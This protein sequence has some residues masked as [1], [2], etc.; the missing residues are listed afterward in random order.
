MKK[1]ILI[2]TISVV[3]LATILIINSYDSSIKVGEKNLVIKEK[4]IK[5]YDRPDLAVLQNNEMTLDPALGY[6]PVERSLQ[7]FE[8][9]RATNSS[10]RALSEDVE[11]IERGPDNVGG[12]TRALMFD[13]N[14]S[15][16]KKVWAGGIGGG[17]WYIND[18]TDASMSWVNV[19]DFLANLAISDIAYDPTNTS[20]FYLS[21]GLAYSGDIRGAGIFKSIDAG[22]TWSQISSTNNSE[23]YFVQ[24]LAIDATGKIY[25]T[26][27][28]G[29]KISS[30]GG[31]TWTT[32][33]EGRAADVE[34]ASNG[35]VYVTFG[36]SSA[37]SIHKSEDNGSTWNEITPGTTARRIEIATAPSN[38]NV[39]YAVADGGPA[40]TDVEWFYKSSDGGASWD[41][42]TIPLYTEQDCTEGTNHFTRGQAFFDLILGVHP[43][44]EN[45]VVV[46]GIDL[47]V[48]RDGG[49]IWS[50][51][52]YWTGSFC[53]AY[54]HAD[55]HA[56]LFRPGYP[57][58]A[59]FGND[60]G[61]SYSDDIGTAANPNFET[62]V[63]GYNVTTFY[64]VAA[65][66]EVNS[67]YFLAGAQDNG[68]QQFTNSFV[69]STNEVTGGDG[70]FCFVDQDDSSIQISSFVFNAYRLSQD[71][72]QSF[73]SIS[74]EQSKG[75]FINPTEYDSDSDVLY[76]AGD[77]DEMTKFTD[78]SGTPSALQSIALD[79]DGRQITH[80]K[81]SPY[82]DDRLFVGVRVSGGEGQIFMIDN[83]NDANPTVTEITGSY[84][85]SHG[86]WVSSI[87]VGASDDHLLATFSNY[88]INSI[89]ETLDGGT[90]WT[91][92]NGD[93][94]DFPVRWGVYNPL[95]R[96][97]V[98][99]A[100]ELGVWSTEDI[101]VASPSWSATNVGLA[102]VRTD[103]IKVRSVDN[104]VAVATFG[105]GVFTTNFISPNAKADFSSPR[106]GYV[107]VPVQFNDASIKP[108]DSWNW[109]F[110]DSNTSTVQNPTNTYT[111]A[112]TY[113]VSL[114]VDNDSDTNSKTDYITILPSIVPP[115]MASDGGDFETNQ[116]HF[117]SLSLLNGVNIWE[118]GTPSNTFDTAPSGSNVWKTDLDSNIGDKGFD[119]KSAIYTPSFDLSETGNYSLKFDLEMAIVYC[120][121]P[122]ALQVQYSTDQS[123]WTT[124][125]SSYPTFGAVNWYNRGDNIGCSIEHDL[126][127][128]KAGWAITT[129]E[130][131]TVEHP[132]NHLVGNSNVSFRIVYAQ[133]AGSAANANGDDPYESDGVLIDDFEISFS[134]TTADFSTDQDIVFTGSEINFSY[135]SV[136][137]LTYSWDFGDGNTSTE[138]NPSHTYE[139]AGVYSVT[140]DITSAS[141]ADQVVRADLITVLGSEELP[142]T[143]ENGGDLETNQSAFIA[144]NIS[145]TPFE[146][147]ISSVTDKEGT[148]SGSFAWVTGLDESEYVDDSEAYLYTSE[149]NFLSLGEYTFGFYSNHRFE[150]NWDGFI[151]EYTTNKGDSWIK[152]NPEIATSWY[153][154]TSDPQSVFGASVP[155]ISGNTDGFEE[156]FTDVSHL[157]GNTS[158]AFRF[159]FLTDAATVDVGMALDDITVDG[160][161]AGNAVAD[162]TAEGVTGCDGQIVTFTNTSSGSISSLSW[163]FGVN[164]TPAT[165]SG[166]GPHDVTYQGSGS[167][168]V[169]LTAEGILNGTQVKEKID[170]VNTSPIHEPTFTSQ[171]NNDGTYTLT[172]SSG[173]S[174]QWLA[175]REIVEGGTNQTLIVQL[176]DPKEYTVLVTIGSCEILS[177]GDVVNSI[178]SESINIYPN[179][180][181]GIVNISSEISLLKPEYSVYNSSGQF[182]A[183]GLFDSGKTFV[184]L[185]DQNSGLYII[186]LNIR[187][188]LITKSIVISK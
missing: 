57:N 69:N 76:A 126:F 22:A 115:Y 152:L 175:D 174:Y 41:E 51:V 77:S 104:V 103:M 166:I 40:S 172:A 6:P 150:S 30:D 71:G 164:A 137:A 10:G 17:L 147:G 130:V 144:D 5:E 145:G 95:D 1:N 73:A 62:R 52:S 44:E 74:E 38:G 180:S 143:L 33:L 94:P 70:A 2:L 142:F 28:D 99:L 139:N 153:N 161:V 156:F 125:G 168:T 42:L 15:E 34:V 36:V 123:N 136:G 185:S 154:Q 81:A 66:N 86:E 31:D 157:A 96:D 98:L 79:L 3:A 19:N 183:K 119:F 97:Q 68:T 121:A 114:G 182:V 39:V 47:H 120:N 23:F 170:L 37:G 45:N 167:S 88:G 92:K 49:N 80:L 186:K 149:F 146:L 13:P 91:D 106:V 133:S 101:T 18:I 165:A 160:P 16:S 177:D 61:V 184:D 32:A 29:L 27:L 187:G 122:S 85:G 117:T 59:I 26:T 108:N 141:G 14:D 25:A 11:W 128:E 56:I 4:G 21:T 67:N 64:S 127:P 135:E 134:G 178:L 171:N 84:S 116:N 82:T 93:L 159:K 12:R 109:N 102:N 55:Q 78:L 129:E 65:A 105:R 148:N 181:N 72:G 75:R 155:I 83:A 90:N 24:R 163:D 111:T 158:V 112:G 35:T 179:P 107:G 48:S 169:T 110:G 118:V 173:D 54:V 87:D 113:S 7:A 124:L 132:L 162:F 138:E 50:N 8:M 63:R 60:G 188:E 9:L 140:L 53:D 131:L 151:V 100:T 46:G 176:G 58:Q 20:T 89:Y 43:N